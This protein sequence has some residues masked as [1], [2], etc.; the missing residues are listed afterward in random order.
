MKI[1]KTK[2]G[3]YTTVIH[4]GKDENGNYRKKR[5]TGASRAEV[6]ASA[7]D[8]ISNHRIAQESTQ[9]LEALNRYITAREASRS[10]A[11]IRGYK[12]IKGVLS[13][14]FAAFCSLKIASITSDQVQAVVDQLIS[15][16][17]SVKTIRNWVGLINSVLTE[18]GGTPA[19]VKI[20]KAPVIDRP[21][22]S[23]GEIK[24]LLCLLHNHPLE[25]PFH[26]AI[27]GLRRGEICAL[28][29]SDLSDDDIL[30]VHKSRVPIYGGGT[31]VNLSAKTDTSNRFVA[32]PHDIAE[33]IRANGCITSYTPN[34]LT[35][36]L[37]KYLRKYKFPPYRLHD[38]RHFFVSYC[39]S[40]GVVE[41]DILSAGGWKTPNIMRAV[42]RH[43]MAKNKASAAISA[44]IQNRSDL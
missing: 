31:K 27:L 13:S 1:T 17:Y 9:F 12:S 15:K 19:N 41:A 23:E 37:R 26:L 4:A 39:H 25:I 40:K 32:I 14:D 10:V 3:K 28:E 22:Y 29:L 34:G 43:S 38:C 33:K 24:M 6:A 44:L 36:A 16:D 2:T 11:T 18:A 7:A 21:I 5:I 30:H 8:Y 42:Y 35:G 20:P